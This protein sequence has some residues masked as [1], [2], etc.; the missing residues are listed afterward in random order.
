MA[1]QFSSAEPHKATAWALK[2]SQNNSAIKEIMERYTS[3]E[4]YKKIPQA[5]NISR[6][7][8]K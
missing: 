1:L 2:N 4:G 6:S 8:I 7:T 3:Y 5:L